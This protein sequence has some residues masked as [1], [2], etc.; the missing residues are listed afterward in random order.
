M[1]D[2]YLVTVWCKCSHRSQHTATRSGQQP[3]GTQIVGNIGH[4]IGLFQKQS[5]LYFQAVGALSF[6]SRNVFFNGPRAAVNVND[7]HGGGDEISHNLFVNS[8]RE[9]GKV[10]QRQ[11]LPLECRGQSPMGTGVACI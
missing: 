11:P 3:W 9:S 8:C 2:C 7:G 6:I 1:R 10:A 5:S 4:E